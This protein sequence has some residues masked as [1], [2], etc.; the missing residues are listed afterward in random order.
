MNAAPLLERTRLVLLV[1]LSL[2]L[3]GCVVTGMAPTNNRNLSV[4]V[5]AYA[6]EEMSLQHIGTTA[7]N[8]V[9]AKQTIPHWNFAKR[10]AEVAQDRL[11]AAKAVASVQLDDGKMT[12]MLADTR[13]MSATAVWSLGTQRSKIAA[14]AEH[15]KT[16]YAI[17]LRTHDSGDYISQTNQ[18]MRKFGVHQRGLLGS[19]DRAF[20]FVNLEGLL[21]DCKTKSEAA[22][23]NFPS[24]VVL[25]FNL[26][27][28]NNLK[29]SDSELQTV[30]AVLEREA[31]SAAMKIYAR[32]GLVP[33]Q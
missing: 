5:I 30:R 9:Y 29:L 15:C 1:A 11:I 25:P 31:G 4:T 3:S 16:D 2:W 24:F 17:L 32:V 14:A 22:Y 28:E 13:P 23:A 8:N 6:N 18:T 33:N 21:I 27:K 20:A 19:V 26:S 10:I 12:A 7:F